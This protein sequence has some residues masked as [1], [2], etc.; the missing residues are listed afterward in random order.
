VTPSSNPSDWPS[1]S[2]WSYGVLELDVLTL[3]EVNERL[4]LELFIQRALGIAGTL[5]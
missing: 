3:S 2:A 4:A 5:D 1:W